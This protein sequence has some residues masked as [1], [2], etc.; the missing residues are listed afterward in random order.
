VAG[1]SV[2]AVRGQVLTADAMDAHNTFERKDAVKP[3]PFS[4]AA[5]GGKLT[6]KVPAKSVMVVAVEG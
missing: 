3:A 4:A 1:Q 5:A 2:N 6:I